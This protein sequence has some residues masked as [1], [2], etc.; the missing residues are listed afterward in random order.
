MFENS[1]IYDLHVSLVE[2]INAIYDVSTSIKYLELN[3]MP[4]EI[5]ESISE[6]LRTNFNVSMDEFGEYCR[7]LYKTFGSF[8]RSLMDLEK[9]YHP[10]KYVTD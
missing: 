2:A 4:I 6:S 5:Q 1:S 3:T 10:N 9:Q 8:D 7:K